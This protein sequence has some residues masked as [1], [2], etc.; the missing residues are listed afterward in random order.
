M[1]VAGTFIVDTVQEWLLCRE[2]LSKALALITRT[3]T[4]DDVVAAILRGTMKL[5]R[6]ESSGVVT[7]FCV[8]PQSKVLNVFLVGGK[9]EE[10]K[11]L[12]PLMRKFAIQNG[13]SGWSALAC[14]KGWLPFLG[15]DA[16]PEGTFIYGDL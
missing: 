10:L 9:L 12:R 5:W 15:D 13:C 2:S 3:H 16:K 4:E 7:E 14:H 8:F 11:P 6:N 1:Q